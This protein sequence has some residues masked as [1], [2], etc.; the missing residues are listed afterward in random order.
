MSER[1]WAKIARARAAG[2]KIPIIAWEEARRAGIPYYAVCAF[3]EHESYGGKNV[4][5]HDVMKCHTHIKGQKVTEE[6]YK[7]YKK[8]RPTCGM[9]GVGPMQL[10]WYSFQD[11]ADAMGGC[12][13]RRINVRVGCQL[14]AAYRKEGNSWHEVAKRYNGSEEYADYHDRLMD[15]WRRIIRD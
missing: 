13:K 8:A 3:L 10:T 1:N 14:I 9:Q 2:C 11:K 15:K 12:W 5:G 6:R 7:A 4:F